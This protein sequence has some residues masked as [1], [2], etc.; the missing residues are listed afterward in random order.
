M[1]AESLELDFSDSL[2]AYGLFL[3]SDLEQAWELV[4]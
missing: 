3:L 1:L 2:I 4:S